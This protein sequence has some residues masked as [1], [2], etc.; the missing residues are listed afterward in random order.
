MRPLA[1]TLFII[2]LSLLGCSVAPAPTP[3]KRV[4]LHQARLVMG[5]L[6]QVSICSDASTE[7]LFGGVFSIAQRHDDLLSN[8]RRDSDISRINM[9]ALG[10]AVQIHPETYSFITKALDIKME[11]QGVVDIAVGRDLSEPWSDIAG[12]R[13]APARDDLAPTLQLIP[14]SAVARIQDVHLV[15]GALGK[16]FALDAMIEYLKANGCSCALINFGQSSLAALGLPPD[17]PTWNL[18]LPSRNQPPLRFSLPPFFL[19]ISRTLNDAGQ[20]HLLNP[21]SGRMIA[22][23]TTAVVI[24]T[25]GFRAEG[26]STADAIRGEEGVTI[27]IE[28]L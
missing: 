22:T 8:Y 25:S 14:P 27:R 28:G 7:E 26:L 5:T 19:S 4:L 2:L 23:D 13:N 9:A 21:H 17:A 16:G 3:E 12:N 18:A 20:P 10:S 1:L 15:T 6:L 11:T 24:S